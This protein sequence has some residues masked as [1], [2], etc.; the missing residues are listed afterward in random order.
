MVGDAGSSRRAKAPTPIAI[1]DP[2]M[3]RKMTLPLVG[4]KT[5]GTDVTY[6]RGHQQAWHPPETE[7]EKTRKTMTAYGPVDTSKHRTTSPEEKKAALDKVKPPSIM[8]ADGTIMQQSPAPTP[9]ATAPAPTPAATAPTP[10]PSQRIPLHVGT[11]AQVSA[12]IIPV[13]PGQDA[14]ITSSGK[15]KLTPLHKTP[16]YKNRPVLTIQPKIDQMTPDEVNR[17]LVSLGDTPVTADDVRRNPYD[18]GWRP[19]AKPMLPSAKPRVTSNP[20]GPLG[21]FSTARELD[22]KMKE[23][24]ANA[25][26]HREE[27]RTAEIDQRRWDDPER[28]QQNLIP[29]PVPTTWADRLD[30][31]SYGNSPRGINVQ[32]QQ[33]ARQ[34]TGDRK[35]SDRYSYLNQ[36]RRGV[37]EPWERE[38]ED[39]MTRERRVRQMRP[40]ER[41]ASLSSQQATQDAKGRVAAYHAKQIA[42]GDIDKDQPSPTAGREAWDA[43]RANKKNQ[44]GN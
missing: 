22:N 33:A 19:S 24:D 18:P 40:D 34:A 7:A 38:Q 17:E 32:H 28:I 9:A 16:D 15:V 37:M 39:S 13:P 4:T 14:T 26:K 11:E 20:S 43:Y 3:T 23:Y 41:P 5:T 10:K 36:V 42:S 8:N 6:N 44:Q 35:G 12:G 1:D 30:E 25:A 31:P 27:L 21:R 29:S 2:K